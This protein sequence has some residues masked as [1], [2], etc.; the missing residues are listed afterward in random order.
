MA[1]ECKAAEAKVGCDAGQAAAPPPSSE[2]AVMSMCMQVAVLQAERRG[3]E[4]NARQVESALKEEGKETFAR[5]E[6]LQAR[7]LELQRAC[8]A[9]NE[10]RHRLGHELSASQAALVAAQE[11]HKDLVHMYHSQQQQMAYVHMLTRPNGNGQLQ[12]LDVQAAAH[13]SLHHLSFAPPPMSSPPPQ[14]QSYAT[15]P[16]PHRADSFAAY[17]PT[18]AAAASSTPLGAVMPPAMPPAIPPAMPPG[19][20]PPAPAP[21]SASPLPSTSFVASQTPS[22]TNYGFGLPSGREK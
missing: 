9:V 11:Q 7:G 1:S 4:E 15:P 19:M 18:A 17:S 21:A 22:V 5:A 2:C 3:Y 6:A 13:P 16:M 12:P 14:R 10:E 8:E 20:L